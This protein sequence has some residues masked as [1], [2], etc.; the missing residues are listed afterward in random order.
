MPPRLITAAIVLFW[1]GMTGWLI[2]REVVPMMLAEAS[3]TIEPDL[4]DEL[5]V[6]VITWTIYHK[7][8][9]AGSA[10]SQV[11]AGGDRSLELHATLNF[12]EPFLGVY[13]LETM[14]RISDDKQLQAIAIKFELGPKLVYEL[15]G[16]VE[17]GAMEPRLFQN[18]VQLKGFELGKVDMT[19]Q[20]SIVTPMNL[21]NRVRNVREGQTWKITMFDPFRGIKNEFVSQFL[22]HMTVPALI[23]EVKVATLDFE[24]QYIPCYKIEYREPGKDVSASTWVR[25]IDG[26]VLQQQ[27]AH[28]GYDMVLK[29]ILK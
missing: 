3:P 29:R 17:D 11:R 10:Y 5:G 19:Q 1:L 4:T 9:R 23:A 14:H 27:S 12:A 6:P 18:G 28:L 26:L 15:R 7:E 8:K 21:V 24:N 25:K 22:K 16:E 20:A 13:K 2:H